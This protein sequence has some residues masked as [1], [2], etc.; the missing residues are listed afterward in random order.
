MKKVKLPKNVSLEDR[1]SSSIDSVTQ[2]EK[3]KMILITEDTYFKCLRLAE[4]MQAYKQFM[5]FLQQRETLNPDDLAQRKKDLY[6]VCDRIAKAREHE[7][8]LEDYL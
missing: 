2:R 6:A 5:S 4:Q 1:V 7:E 3:K 8:E